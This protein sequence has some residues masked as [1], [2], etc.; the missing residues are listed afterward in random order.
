MCN[1]IDGVGRHKYRGVY[2]DPPHWWLNLFL[3]QKG[4]SREYGT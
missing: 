4:W 1:E 2:P 3:I